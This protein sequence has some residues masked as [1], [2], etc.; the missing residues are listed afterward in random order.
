[1][2]TIRENIETAVLGKYDVIVVGGGP[3][4]VSA[5]I[6]AARRGASVLLT[7]KM[8]CL[9]GMWTSGLVNPVFDF[10][11]KGGILLEIINDLKAKNAWGGF[12]GK[13]FNY[14]YMKSLLETKCLE[15]G[16]D[17]LYE[18][19]CVGVMKEGSRVTGV[20]LQNIEGRC[21]Y[22]SS[23]VIDASGDGFVCDMAGAKW[24]FGDTDG[25]VQAA[26]LMFLVGGVPEKYRDGLQIY[27]LLKAAF[28]RQNEGREPVFNMPYLITVPNTDIAVIQMAHMC[29]KD[30]LT[31][32][33]KTEMVIEGRKQALEAFEALRYFDPDFKS[34]CIISSAP[35][36][37]V[38]ESRRIVCEYCITDNDLME[39]SKFDDAVTSC[40]FY[41]DIHPD[42]KN[43]VQTVIKTKPYH[44]PYRSLVPKG[45][46]GI[47]VAGRTISGTHL[48][49]ASF[50]VT[51]TCSAMGEAAGK[52]A[53]YSALNDIPLRNVKAE[54]FKPEII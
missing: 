22:E 15:A 42:G 16:V 20:I 53:A 47:L 19:I 52:A 32:K 7:E 11:D 38:R 13:C 5:A 54:V 25:N 44:I 12:W 17:V 48:A 35:A 30:C 24:D 51:G 45:L 39:G 41:V 10:N 49:M 23:I 31:S 1:M 28:D 26:T 9:G 33:G 36:L 34:L 27:A 6:S 43:P 46:E 2:K 50:R 14:E 37:G 3:A 21:A 4:G 40:S 8:N 29:A 18:S